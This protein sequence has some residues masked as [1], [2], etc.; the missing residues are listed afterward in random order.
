MCSV[1]SQ[2]NLLDVVGFAPFCVT[3]VEGYVLI[4]LRG[5]PRG[6]H[7]ACLNLLPQG[8]H[9]SAVLGDKVRSHF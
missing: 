5:T 8:A 9:S 7:S 3:I 4:S 1:Y 2:A 6:P